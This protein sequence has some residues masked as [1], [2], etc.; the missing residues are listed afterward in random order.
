M[1]Y[2]GEEF[3]NRL[4]KLEL[5]VAVYNTD[6]KQSVNLYVNGNEES[7][8]EALDRCILFDN[9]FNPNDTV[10]SYELI[11]S[12]NKTHSIKKNKEFIADI[13]KAI[14]FLKITLGTN[15]KY[16]S[17]IVNLSGLNLF[18]KK[19]T[20]S[21]EAFSTISSFVPI[22][23]KHST[24]K[25]RIDDINCWRNNISSTKPITNGNFTLLN[26]NF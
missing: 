1:F 12:N 14:N 5:F 24:F 4:L 22:A 19:Y 7:Q 8:I 10:L 21:N 9:D 18:V 20:N 3:S 23:P 11:D 13:T 16:V 17:P 26:T 2:N 6:S 25:F 15:N